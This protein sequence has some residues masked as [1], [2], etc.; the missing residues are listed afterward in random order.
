[1]GVDDDAGDAAVAVLVG[2]DVAEAGG[3]AEDDVLAGGHG[4]S[5]GAEVLDGLLG[6][7]GLDVGRGA[8]GGD[9]DVGGAL[10]VFAS[11]GYGHAAGIGQVD[12]ARCSCVV[13]AL[14]GVAGKADGHVM[15][16]V[17]K[18]SARNCLRH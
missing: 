15:V 6:T 9:G 8:V 11:G 10:D 3:R 2:V 18:D 12:V 7:R 14:E 4:D 17:D 13:D 5:A 16:V 1:A